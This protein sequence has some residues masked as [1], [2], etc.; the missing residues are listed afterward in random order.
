MAQR[1]LNFTQAMLVWTPCIFYLCFRVR[2]CNCKN[3]NFQRKS[4]IYIPNLTSIEYLSLLHGSQ[5]NG[6]TLQIFL[7]NMTSGRESHPKIY[8]WGFKYNIMMNICN[9]LEP[10]DK[11][12]SFHTELPT[13]YDAARKS[14]W[15]N[16][17][18][19]AVPCLPCFWCDLS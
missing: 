12:L 13:N 6:R 10:V 9:Y 2:A 8:C 15:M 3:C 7:V 16:C 19:C 18:G 1:P 17:R 5:N 11:K 14:L 4:T